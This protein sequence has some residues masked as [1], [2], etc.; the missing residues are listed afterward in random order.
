MMDPIDDGVKTLFEEL[1]LAAFWHRPSILVA[2][3]RSK[4]NY[5]DASISLAKK[6]QKI[7]QIVVP[8]QVTPANFDI[9]RILSEIPEKQNKIFFVNGL[10]HG[11]GQQ[12]LNAYRA[13]NFRRELLVDHQ[14]R[15]VF[16]LQEAEAALL[17]TQALDFWSFRH[18]M[19]E[20]FSEPTYRRINTL[21]RY[22]NWPSWQ[23]DE[24]MKE[25]P[26]GV[27]LR[28]ELLNGIPDWKKASHVRAEILHMLAA[29]HWAT[30][31]YTQSL[32]LLEKGLNMAQGQ[33]LLPLRARYWIGIGK[34]QVSQGKHDLAVKALQNSINIDPQ[35]ADAWFTLAELYKSQKQLLPAVE[36]VDQSISINPKFSKGWE[37][38]GDV[39]KDL[40]ENENALKSYKKSLSINKKGTLVWMKLG[41]TYR[42]LGRPA[43]A[44]P[45]F[46]HARLLNTNN[47]D[48][49]LKLGL[50]LRDVGLINRAI[51]ALYKAARLNPQVALPWK[52]LGDIYR[53][54]NNLK[55][56]RKAYKT[57]ASL[58][59]QDQ[60]L[61]YSLESCYL[62]RNKIMP[63][64]NK[65]NHSI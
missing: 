48:A 24:L 11:G 47:P 22:L 53:A 20:L 8:Y 44:L 50:A 60:T 4:L 52:K 18:R 12:G 41:D 14:I 49:W 17:P 21:V 26:D 56:A 39:Y 55:Y 23:L 5:F 38:M 19:V 37:L 27:T 63:D 36:A 33:E 31:N 25:I 13:L 10:S 32:S 61:S 16:W 46:D 45:A 54:K 3:Y 9:P 34:V 1:K 40:G 7:K 28:E 30:G 51:R 35:S 43:D 64:G 57:A 62:R 58:D 29:L 42:L 59:P 2:A 15:A 6:L 65:A